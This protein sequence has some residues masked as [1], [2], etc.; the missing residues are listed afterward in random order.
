MMGLKYYTLI[1]SEEC[2]CVYACLRERESIRTCREE[3]RAA[4]AQEK[5]R[6]SD[7][8]REREGDWFVFPHSK[9]QK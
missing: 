7:E 8:G 4:N 5:E 6:E 3:S 9:S 2:V 1:V